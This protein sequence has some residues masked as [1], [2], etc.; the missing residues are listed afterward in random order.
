LWHSLFALA[1]RVVIVVS[2][3]TMMNPER[4]RSGSIN[5]RYRAGDE[6]IYHTYSDQY[7]KWSDVPKEQYDHWDGEKRILLVVTNE[8][9]RKVTPRTPMVLQEIVMSVSKTFTIYQ[10]PFSLGSCVVRVPEHLVDDVKYAC[11]E[12]APSIYKVDVFAIR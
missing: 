10:D 3:C 5:V 1:L 7:G 6:L 4:R 2:I 12:R 9:G 11:H 8:C